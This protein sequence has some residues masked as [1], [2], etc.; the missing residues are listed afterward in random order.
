MDATS[1]TSAASTGALGIPLDVF[2]QATF[3]Q[4]YTQLC[5]AYPVADPASH[6]TIISTL[7]KGLERLSKSFPWTAGQVINERASGD[8]TGVFKIKSF[9]RS[10][11]LVVNDLSNDSS[12]PTM[13]VLKKANFPMSLLDESIIAPRRT[14]PGSPDEAGLPSPV[15]MLQATFIARGL[16]LTIIS[17]HATMDIIGQGQLMGLL[18][19]A[20]HDEPFTEEEIRAGNL[21]R[22]NLIPLLEDYQPGPEISHLIIKT[23]PTTIGSLASLKSLATATKPPSVPFISTDDALCALTWQAVTR[24]R[25]PR[26]TPNTKPTFGRALDARPYMDTIPDTYAGLIFSCVSTSP[27]GITSA[28]LRTTLHPEVSNTQHIVRATATVLSRS[29]DRDLIGPT[30][31]IDTSTDITTSSWAKINAYSLDFNLGLGAP[32]AVRRPRFTPVEGLIYFLPKA[33]DG[34]MGVAMCLRDEDLEQLKGR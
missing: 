22:R 32:L 17:Q 28:N 23:P 21:D 14:L 13:D 20:C 30:A 11:T 25:L 24:A 18:S 10:A 8:N 7:Q 16:L 27:L 3:L 12:I 31:S 9:Q 1:T 2:G 29:A 19:K 33:L 6:T 34:E 5:L 15:L 26:L 4:I